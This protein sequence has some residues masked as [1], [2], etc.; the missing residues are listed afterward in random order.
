MAPTSIR[1]RLDQELVARKLARTRS[2][3]QWLIRAGR[4]ALNGHVETRPGRRVSPAASIELLEPLH[5]VSRG[6]LKLEHA[7]DT[8]QINPSGLIAVDVGASTGGFTDCLLQRGAARV[9]AIDV[10]HGQLAEKLRGDPRVINMESTDARHLESL[11]EPIDLAV[12]DVS[13]ISL[14]LVVPNIRRWLRPTGD[15]V[16]LIKP[17]FEAGPE[18]VGRGGV[19]RDPEVHRAV[20]RELLAWAADQ[21]LTT[22][23]LTPSPILGSDGNREFLVHWRMG[24]AHP[25]ERGEPL[26]EACV[27]EG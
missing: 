17:Q 4:V 27:G 6:G 15:I 7:L 19:I 11:P 3:A 12:I 23:N 14:R 26:I 20:L 10:G 21:G 25:F 16:A 22:L 13:F 9:Y 8:F 2:Q 18:R 1:R 24:E 5:Y